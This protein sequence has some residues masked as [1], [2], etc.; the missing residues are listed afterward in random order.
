MSQT[1]PP[2]PAA[3]SSAATPS[4]FALA[5]RNMLLLFGVI[6][7]IVGLVMLVIGLG[8]VWSESRFAAE[9]RSATG[10]VIGKEID[11]ASASEDRGTRY[12]VRYRFND[13][14]G[15]QI[16]G[17]DT[18]SFDAWEA[19][20]EGG[21]VEVSYLAGDPG[22]NRVAGG[23]GI[24]VVAVIVVLGLALIAIGAP[25]TIRGWRGVSVAKRLW[26]DGTSATGTVTGTEQTNVQVN[27]R[28][29]WRIR[30]RYADAAGATHEGQS[31]YVS[32]EEAAQWQTGSPAIV[33]Y[34]PRKPG[35]SVWIG[36]E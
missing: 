28:N 26:R 23:E 8:L 29:L 14:E 16:D 35:V 21:P 17:S 4:T 15:R 36:E 19:L 2:P 6:L 9:G 33:R 12:I 31:G 7:L 5:R 27:R 25:L 24:A 34:D 20:T 3:R 30:Y 32:Y 13:A 10:T 11:R 1:S 22:T 18:V